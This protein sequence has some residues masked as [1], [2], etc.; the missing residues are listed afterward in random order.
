MKKAWV[1]SYPLS[2]QR[3]LWSDCADAQA[4]LSLRDAHSL[5]WSLCHVVTRILYYGSF[6]DEDPKLLA[7][8]Q[9]LFCWCLYIYCLRFFF[10]FFFFFFLLTTLL[11]Q[12]IQNLIKRTFLFCVSIYAKRDRNVNLYA[13]NA[14]QSPHNPLLECWWWSPANRQVPVRLEPSTEASHVLP[15]V[16]W[17][18]LGE[19]CTLLNLIFSHFV[20]VTCIRRIHTNTSHFGMC[21]IYVRPILRF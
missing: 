17:Y 4:D 6:G 1:L 14:I 15:R 9:I 7:Y 11:V 2:A 8:S 12:K 19:Q 3:R 16:D 18:S 10:F 21:D 20:F 13:M 5:C